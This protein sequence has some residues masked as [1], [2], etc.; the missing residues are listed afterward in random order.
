LVFAIALECNA[1]DPLIG[2]FDFSGNIP[3]VRGV[4]I[5][6]SGS[7][8]DE[9]MA[10]PLCDQHRSPANKV[11]ITR[12]CAALNRRAERDDRSRLRLPPARLNSLWEAG[13]V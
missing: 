11:R 8:V 6:H 2:V 4:Y 3:F 13:H 1:R 7:D 9:R 12:S 5:G 10:E